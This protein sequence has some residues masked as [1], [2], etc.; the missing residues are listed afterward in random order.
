MS[1]VYRYDHWMN[2][3]REIDLAWAA[4][5]LDGEGCFRAGSR[6][7]TEHIRPEIIAYQATNRAPIDRLQT[8]LGGRVYVVPAK[9][10]TGRQQ[11]RWHLEGACNLVEV[12]PLLL[13]HLSVKQE[14]ALAL[15]KL[16]R[17]MGITTR[18]SDGVKEQRNA[19]VVELRDLKAVI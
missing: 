3:S 4:G 18:I 14:Q 15:L 5:F 6:G 19:L 10:V 16:V 7:K 9:T 13:P 11:Y 2:L 17:L 8:I 12:I 1:V